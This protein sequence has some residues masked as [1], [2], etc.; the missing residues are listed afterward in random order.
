[1]GEQEIDL[2]TQKLN[3]LENNVL[4][5]TTQIRDLTEMLPAERTKKPQ[6][7]HVGAFLVYFSHVSLCCP[8]GHILEAA[9][10]QN[11]LQIL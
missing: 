8:H 5:K 3:L 2:L 4:T 7:L 9:I 1:M 6:K 10:I 11:I